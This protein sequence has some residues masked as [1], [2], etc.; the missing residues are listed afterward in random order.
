M[1]SVRP[2]AAESITHAVAAGLPVSVLVRTVTGL[3]RSTAAELIDAGHHMIDTAP[4]QLIIRPH[5]ARIV[6]DPPRL[7]D[8]LF[9]IGADVPDP[10]RT[11]AG[12]QPLT[13]ALRHALTIPVAHGASEAL[14]VSASFVGQRTYSRFD[15][16]DLT[17]AVIA[18]RTGAVY[19]SRRDGTR[20]PSERTDWRV[21]FDGTRARVAVR[22]FDAPLHRRDWRGHTVTGSLHP[23]VAAALARL[24]RIGPGHR[25][26]DPFCGAGTIVLEARHGCPTA[27]YTG[28]DHDPGAVEAARAN[29]PAQTSVSWQV[30]DARHVY[31]T[32]DCFDRIITNPPWGLRLPMADFDAHVR[33]W[34]RMLRPTGMLVAILTPGQAQTVMGDARWRIIANHHVAVAGQHPRIVMAKPAT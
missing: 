3:E 23:P 27:A 33:H 14:S 9:V 13:R 1:P 30:G 16:E 4:R 21:V 7:A 15:I 20:P 25:V 22:P 26:L 5:S 18:E 11:R 32:G 2:G 12:L 10:G 24:A 29:T 6:T 8:D 19:Y 17:G 31:R 34:C 28:L